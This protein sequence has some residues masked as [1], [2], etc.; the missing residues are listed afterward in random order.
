MPRKYKRFLSLLLLVAILF[1]QGSIITRADTVSTDETIP[2]EETVQPYA[3]ILP[4]IIEIGSGTLTLKFSLSANTLYPHRGVNTYSSGKCITTANIPA[5]SNSIYVSGSFTRS[6]SNTA[7]NI[8]IG[9][10]VYDPN[11]NV[12]FDDINLYVAP[13]SSFTRKICDR[14]A[15]TPGLQYYG[16]IHNEGSSGTISGSVGFYYIQ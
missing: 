14:S 12:V 10:G 5:N 4:S 3:V 13:V 6:T 1:G 9:L 16:V 8:R 15:L 2:N 7:S 11:R